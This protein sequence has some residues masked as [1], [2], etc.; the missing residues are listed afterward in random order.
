VAITVAASGLSL[1]VA[2]S[3]QRPGPETIVLASS[4]ALH[5]RQTNPGRMRSFIS[6]LKQGGIR[7]YS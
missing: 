3:L 1:G 2:A 6:R 5:A 4:I 7:V